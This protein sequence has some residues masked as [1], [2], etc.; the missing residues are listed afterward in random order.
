MIHKRWKKTREELMNRYKKKS[1]AVTPEAS[2]IRFEML[3]MNSSMEYWHCHR[4][5]FTSQR[6]KRDVYCSQSRYF[7]DLFLHV[8]VPVRFYRRLNICTIS[9]ITVTYYLYRHQHPILCIYA[10]LSRSHSLSV[11][12]IVNISCFIHSA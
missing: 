11:F 8:V 2:E 7:I 4:C 9:M 6:Q 1:T 3:N 12:M 5:D 10:P